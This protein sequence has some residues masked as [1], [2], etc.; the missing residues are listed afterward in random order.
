[1]RTFLMSMS[2][3]LVGMATNAE[4]Q[5]ALR[6][7][8]RAEQRQSVRTAEY[9]QST[10]EEIRQVGL[11][12]PCGGVPAACDNC[13]DDYAQ[14]S[15]GCVDNCGCVGCSSGLF[16]GGL[17]GGCG[18]LFGGAVVDDCCGG[19]SGCGLFGGC[20]GGLLCHLGCH[21]RKIKCGCAPGPT[22]AVPYPRCF[23]FYSPCVVRGCTDPCCK[24]IFHEMCCD[25]K[26]WMHAMSCKAPLSAACTGAC[27]INPV[28]F[29]DCGVCCGGC[30][31]GCSGGCLDDCSIGCPG[32]GLPCFL[33]QFSLQDLL[34]AKCVGGS[35]RCHKP[36]V[37]RGLGG[38]L[39]CGGKGCT[40]FGCTS[41][42]CGDGGWGGGYHGGGYYGDGYYGEGY[43][44]DRYYGDRYY[45][46]RYYGDR[47]YGDR[48]YGDRYYGDR[49][50]GD[51]YHGD[52][53]SGDGYYSESSTGGNYANRTSTSHR[54][55]ATTRPG[56]QR[57]EFVSADEYS[58]I[59]ARHA[60]EAEMI[61]RGESD[62]DGGRASAPRGTRR[63]AR[64]MTDPQSSNFRRTARRQPIE[65]VSFEEEATLR[66]NRPR[67]NSRDAEEMPY[68]EFA[69]RE[70]HD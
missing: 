10:D 4:A 9:S 53:Y 3:V 35:G 40:G 41:D 43:Y 27:P 47:Y 66:L 45:G 67:I 5:V 30:T 6:R 19:C 64:R 34:G 12:E 36:S 2:L 8:A 54:Y 33:P 57:A 38:L 70:Y 20:G 50:H 17:F 42:F 24:T 69:D 58:R 44:G 49:Y 22:C 15:C 32:G 31:D 39:F 60:E 28:G 7:G 68:L 52:G 46:D 18:G 63:N 48:Y 61:S 51:R 11:D 65:R 13:N 1:M 25:V 14:D 16:G 56:S 23:S 62:S 37:L 26:N 59:Q 29:R 55:Y 21:E